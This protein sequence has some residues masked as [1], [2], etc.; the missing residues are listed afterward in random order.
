MI[1][2][3][4]LVMPSFRKNPMARGVTNKVKSVCGE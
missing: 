4:F 3:R 1:R 2:R